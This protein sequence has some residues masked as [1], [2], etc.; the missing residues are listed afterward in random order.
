MYA[1]ID[2]NNNKDTETHKDK[3]NYVNFDRCIKFLKWHTENL[4]K[5]EIKDIVAE[6]NL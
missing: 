2:L 5:K 4:K 1:L 6:F 3:S